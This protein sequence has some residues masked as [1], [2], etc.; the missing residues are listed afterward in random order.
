M[1]EVNLTTFHEAEY[2]VVPLANMTPAEYNP[3]LD[4]KPGDIA[5]D[6][7]KKSVIRYGLLQPIVWNSRTGNIVGGHQRFKI[8]QE[9]GATE[10]MCA[11]VDKSLEDEMA[12]NI[13]MNKA[14]GRWEN[15]LLRDMFESMDRATIDYDA[16]GFDPE[17]VDH[18]FTQL[19]QLDDGDIFDT[20]MEP[21][22]KPPMVTCPHCGKKFE[23]RENRA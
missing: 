14:R 16:L 2:K 15:D 9:M 19:D 17:E 6:R 20:D 5:Y 4:L 8:L 22:K 3:R 7:L 12:A 21:E 23:E 11:V 18:L 10:V 1:D 13:A